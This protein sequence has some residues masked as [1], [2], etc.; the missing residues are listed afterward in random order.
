MPRN[1]RSVFD[2]SSVRLRTDR[3]G[4]GVARRGIRSTVTDLKPVATPII[5]KGCQ[6]NDGTC[7]AKPIRGSTLCVG[8]QRQAEA[9][10]A[11]EG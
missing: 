11:D 10:R 8:H 5:P 9:R 4:F 3:E 7:R 1:V 2:R 6:G